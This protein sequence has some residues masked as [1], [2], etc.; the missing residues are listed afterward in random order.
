MALTTDQAA[1]ISAIVAAG[2]DIPSITQVAQAAVATASQASIPS[3]PTIDPTQIVAFTAWLMDGQGINDVRGE[4]LAAIQ[5]LTS[6]ATFIF[7]VFQLFKN[8]IYGMAPDLGATAQAAYQAMLALPVVSTVSVAGTVGAV[9]SYQ[10]AATNSPT[11]YSAVGLSSDLSLDTATGVIF[12]T[13]ATP[14]VLAV[15]VI[16]TNAAG[17]G[18]GVVTITVTA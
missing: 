5:S 4:A 7:H 17:S 14:G 12:G 2:G 1:Q 16:A 18:N 13:P 10:V 6:P 11:S 3:L 9:F 15:A 8:L